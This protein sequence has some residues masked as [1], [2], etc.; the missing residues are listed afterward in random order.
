M[1]AECTSLREHG[2]LQA[3]MGGLAERR[4]EVAEACASEGGA[5]IARLQAELER[6][7]GLYARA[8]EQNG[9][10][11]QQQQVRGAL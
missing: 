1:Q 2:A 7:Q 8:L 5:D 11:V 9:A 4:T 6:L 10:L 3:K